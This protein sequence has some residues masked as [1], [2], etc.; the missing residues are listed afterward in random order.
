M[1]GSPEACGARPLHAGT[2]TFSYTFPSV[3]NKKS[4]GTITE[5]QAKDIVSREEGSTALACR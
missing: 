1:C 3:Q 2:K 4:P 5:A